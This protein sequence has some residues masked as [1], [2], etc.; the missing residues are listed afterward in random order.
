MIG[1]KELIESGE[2]KVEGEKLL[3][4]VVDFSLGERAWKEQPCDRQ[5]LY[6]LSLNGRPVNVRDLEVKKWAVSSGG[7]TGKAVSMEV[8]AQGVG[9]IPTQSTK[10]GK[11]FSVEKT[12]NAKRI[13]IK[14]K[15]EYIDK[16]PLPADDFLDI[17]GIA[18]QIKKMKQVQKMYVLRRLLEGATYKQI[19]EETNLS[20]QMVNYFKNQKVK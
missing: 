8:V 18:E 2:Y 7:G 5:G 3:R 16:N 19:M 6:I 17:K 20:K 1:L 13:K 14:P 4:F 12:V 11:A 10:V 15:E 9:L